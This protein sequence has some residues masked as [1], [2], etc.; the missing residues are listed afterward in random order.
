MINESFDLNIIKWYSFVNINSV[1]LIG[2]N[3]E[4]YS[5]LSKKFKKILAIEDINELKTED[6]EQTFDY[7]V[8]YG[9]ENLKLNITDLDELID[10]K[11]KILIIG[12]NYTGINNWSKYSTNNT[13]E[14]LMLKKNKLDVNSSLVKIKSILEKK[15]YNFNEFFV[16][17]NY[18]N[19][20]L[21]IES[22][23]VAN[24]SQIERY[25]P[26]FCENEIKIFDE[27]D[28]LDLII[29]TKPEMMEFFTNSYFIE[30]SKGKIEEKI[31]LVT[32]NNCRKEKYRLITIIQDNVVE[33]IPAN[34]KAKSHIQ[35]MISIIKDL[36]NTELDI[37]DYEDNDHIYSKFIKDYKTLDIILYEKRENFNDIENILNNLKQ[38]LLPYSKENEDGLHILKKAYWDMIPKNCFYI[39]GKFIFFDQEWQKE[40]LSI[41]FIIYRSIINSYDLVKEINVDKLLEK[42][43]LIQYKEQFE[44]IDAELRNEIID[45]KIY[46]EMYNKNI[47]TI[48]NIIN[49]NKIVNKQIEDIKQDNLNKQEYI[50]NLERINK[51]L[52]DKVK[53]DSR[54]LVKLNKIEKIM[55]W[56]K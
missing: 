45:E 42:M 5:E 22:N 17:P 9:M 32:F 2:K 15:K 31:K 43:K 21:I 23:F 33:K 30:A 38:L 7:I 13:E 19:T 47:K 28:A 53:E 26:M 25:N 49:D 46:N 24:K 41:E 50:K 1:L 12:D 4:I 29:Q 18:K 34:I 20:E 56:R 52:E 6:K 16:F 35:N 44:K 40:N 8:I 27:I 55:F 39:D 36:K 51:E 54:K 11:S 37:L 3:E 10:E 48:D 14:L